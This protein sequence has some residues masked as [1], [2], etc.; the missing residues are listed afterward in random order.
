MK[1][2]GIVGEGYVGKA[3]HELFPDADVYDG[4]K[5]IGSRAVINTC[6]VVFV[7]VPTPLQEGKLDTS[8]VEE[9]VEWCEADVICLRSTVNPGDSD[10]WATDYEKRIVVQP[11]YMGESP[12]HPFMDHSER[13]FMILGGKPGDRRE[14]IEAYQQVYN[15]N[16]NIRQVS[17]LEA[18]IIKLSE[19]RAIAWKVAQAQ[20]LYDACEEAGVD[21]YT[22]R[23]AVYGDDPRFNLWHTF[24]YPEKRGMSSSC[25]PKDVYAWAAWA[26]SVG[27]DARMTQAILERN[28][29]WI[30]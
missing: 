21:Y 5:G 25:I 13:P 11:E 18:E 29:E 20:E 7:C 23:D 22:V 4:P 6:E 19:N 16:I 30:S 3:Q 14:V 17:R 24:V 8:I 2:V 1:R 28:E 10:G 26:E 12:A 27:A 15:A 9:V